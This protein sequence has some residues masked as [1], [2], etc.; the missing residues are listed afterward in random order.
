MGG[1]SSPPC[2]RSPVLG[3]CKGSLVQPP[4]L[5]DSDLVKTLCLNCSVSTR[6]HLDM[7][8]PGPPALLP[9]ATGGF[10]MAGPVVTLSAGRE[11]AREAAR[12]GA[13]V[14][15]GS[16]P[17]PVERRVALPRLE[18]VL[19]VGQPATGS[20]LLGV[21]PRLPIS[22]LPPP[23]TVG[24][25]RPAA[26]RP[27]LRLALH[28]PLLLPG[29]LLPP[30]QPMPRVRGRGTAPRLSVFPASYPSPAPGGS[31]LPATACHPGGPPHWCWPVWPLWPRR[32]AGTR[33][34]E[35]R[36]SLPAFP[37]CCKGE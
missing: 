19:P 32:G 33:L 18:G 1:G 27:W 4:P 36:L 14:D 31:G 5:L 37:L 3:S 20:A 2:V 23:E 11:Q 26:G 24:A 13:L 30:A 7:A 28:S 21:F 34:P 15:L 6:Y 8:G 16:N 22:M 12:A 9:L 35:S 25:V 10:G 29:V 17:A